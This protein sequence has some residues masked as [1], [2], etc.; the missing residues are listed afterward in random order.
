MCSPQLLVICLTFQILCTI[1]AVAGINTS[2]GRITGFILASGRLFAKPLQAIPSGCGYICIATSDR[3]QCA[4][5]CIVPAH[6]LTTQ[7]YAQVRAR[8]SHTIQ[9]PHEAVALAVSRL[10]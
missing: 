1:V 9:T 3:S 5:P 6:R 2:K 8:S 4:C 7:S 10:L